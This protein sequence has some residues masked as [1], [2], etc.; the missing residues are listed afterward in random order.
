MKKI[1]RIG[2]SFLLALLVALSCVGCKAQK[3]TDQ[4]DAENQR[5]PVEVRAEVDRAEATTADT[6]TFR[7]TLETDPTT[8]VSLPEIGA[9]IQGLRV[10][11]M[12][13]EPPTIVEGRK[14]IQKS[15]TLKAD[16]EGSY[17][18]PA[19]R[20]SYKD[21]EGKEQTAQTAQIF[22]KV[23]GAQPQAGQEQ[24]LRDIKPLQKIRNDLP[25]GLLIALAAFLAI[26]SLLI[27][28]LVRHQ[29]RAKAMDKT[30]PPETLAKK[31]LADLFA[32]GLLDEG[33][34]RA[35]VFGLSII[36]RR[37][38]ERKY[39]I[40]AAEHTTE[41][42]VADLREAT[43]IGEERK[44]ATRHFLSEIDPVRYRGVEPSEDEIQNWIAQL[45][46]FIQI[47]ATSNQ[48]EPLEEAA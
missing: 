1:G 22:V 14:R 10:I 2:G 5:P 18:L 35:F 8:D 17:I 37:Y 25:K 42:I 43:L 32:S 21:P 27:F 36:F 45:E 39:Q 26:V 11:D 29:R 30:L 12:G 31:E 33:H 48:E 16:I 19:I 34:L 47:P 38:L 7:V 13:E 20:V 4:G 44:K 15:Y 9:Q 6:V 24:D 28:M 46:D 40:R 3:Q 41:E 23:K